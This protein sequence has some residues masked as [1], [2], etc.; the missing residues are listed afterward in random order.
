MELND[1]R[2]VAARRGLEAAQAESDRLAD[3]ETAVVSQLS[4]V[5]QELASLRSERA[6]LLEAAAQGRTVDTSKIRQRLVSLQT[7]AEELRE[8]HAALSRHRT[9]AEEAVEQAHQAV[10]KAQGA[11]AL[12]RAAELRD[13]LNDVARQYE[14]AWRAL[15]AQLA[16]ASGLVDHA[17]RWLEDARNEFRHP[18]LLFGSSAGRQIAMPTA[19]SP[20]YS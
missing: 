8:M 5:E 16:I 12:E 10:K 4:G 13:A 9:A 19:G 20:R 17:P 3:R 7:A 11:V 6:A 15:A 14:E 1:V 2:I 18:S